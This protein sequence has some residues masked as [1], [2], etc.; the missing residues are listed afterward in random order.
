M[1]LTLPS[2][3]V[4]ALA[5]FPSAWSQ[6]APATGERALRAW[7][8]MFN[9]GDA[10]R[11]R[12]FHE[13]WIG[14][15]DMPLEDR[16]QRELELRRQTGGFTLLKVLEATDQRASAQLR[17]NSSGAAFIVELELDP[18]PPH[19]ITM[20]GLRPDEPAGPP[21]ERLS[22]AGFAAAVRQ[23]LD[24][25]AAKDR[26]SGAVSVTRNG[27]E[28]IRGAWGM[29]DREKKIPN[30]PDTKFN[31]GSMNKMFTAVAIAQLAQA[32]KLRFDDP[33]GRHLKDY[34]NRDVAE[35]VTIHHLLTHT[36]GTGDI[37]GPEFDR[38][39]AKLRGLKDYVALYGAR[40]PAFPPGSRWAYSN[41]GYILLGR[42]IEEVSGMSYYSY[43]R[44]KIFQ[45]AGMK[46]T[47]SFWKT[48]EVENLARGYDT[49]PDGSHKRNDET[50]PMRGTS[51]GGGYSTVDDLQ[52]FAAAL[53]GHKLLDAKHTALLTA[54]HANTGRRG[55]YGYGFILGGEGRWRWFGH[56]GGAPGINADLRVFPETGY[57]VAVLSN[58]PP[59]AQRASDWITARLPEP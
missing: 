2:A 16:V 34:P 35:K 8:E 59:S 12:Q 29:A 50:L 15:G 20:I 6:P 30:R 49:G 43:V 7:L 52:R 36:G 39:I 46:D 22:A 54:P 33:V 44:E 3:F 38:N 13:Q 31:L 58:L 24:G 45:P 40:A 48:E 41:Y 47:A 28:M 1:R 4:L 32:G 10:A 51:A 55:A 14:E 21:P 19:R 27:R 42:I 53:L 37:F 23:H 5:A 18:A 25:L 9:S 26:F 17:M 11:A 57:A 56:G